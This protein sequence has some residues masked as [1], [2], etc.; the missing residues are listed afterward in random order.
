[1]LVGLSLVNAVA[2]RSGALLAVIMN[3]VFIGAAASAIARGL[4]IECGC[5]TAVKSKVGW[6]LIG[7]DLVF[8]ALG[9]I[10]LLHPAES[11]DRA[12]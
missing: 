6:A 7:R 4:D 2:T 5:I 3:L 9:L 10:A 12:H 11:R 1:V 8:L